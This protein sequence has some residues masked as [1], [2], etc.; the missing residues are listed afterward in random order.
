LLLFGGIV[1]KIRGN[2]LTQ[3]SPRSSNSQPHFSWQATLD[4]GAFLAYAHR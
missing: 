2:D 4:T 3:R 1:S